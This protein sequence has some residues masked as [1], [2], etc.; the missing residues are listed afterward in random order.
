[1]LHKSRK[2]REIKA[3]GFLFTA[4]KFLEKCLK[5]DQMCTECVPGLKNGDLMIFV[6]IVLCIM[7]T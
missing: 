1:M 2:L 3:S 7:F 6:C 4:E 5:K